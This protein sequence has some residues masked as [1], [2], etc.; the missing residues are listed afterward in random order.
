LGQVSPDSGPVNANASVPEAEREHSVAVAPGTI[1]GER[2]TQPV[3]RA[4]E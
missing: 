4:P 1:S 2:C 3:G